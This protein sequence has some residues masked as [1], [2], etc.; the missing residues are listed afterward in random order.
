MAHIVKCL[1]CG[2]SFDRDK[3]ACVQVGRRYA[4]ETCPQSNNS[5]PAAIQREA[6]KNFFYSY[7]KKIYGKNYNYHLINQQA[8]SYIQQYGYTWGGMA[9]ALHWFYELQQNSIEESNGG[10]GILP[11]IYEQAKEIR[12]KN[13]AI[14]EQ[15][16]YISLR[17]P[18]VHFNIQSPRAWQRPPQ[19]LDLE[20]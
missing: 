15:N 5:D 6:D 10:V 12:L 2:Q 3:I 18:I 1:K 16:K 13:L 14:E 7:V 17:Q 8:E 19:L 4:H 11:F 9:W 20:E